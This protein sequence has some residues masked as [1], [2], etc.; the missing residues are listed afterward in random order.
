MANLVHLK[1]LSSEE[2]EAQ[3]PKI[4][5]KL[6]AFMEKTGSERLAARGR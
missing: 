5:E 6:D 4:R 1:E 2:L 3:L